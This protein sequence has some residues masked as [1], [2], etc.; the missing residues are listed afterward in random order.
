MRVLL[1]VDGVV[2]DIL[3]GLKKD[4]QLETDLN[5]VKSWHFI[6]HF[7]DSEKDLI[8]KRMRSF[9][10]WNGLPLV[11]GAKEGV[12]LLRKAG[13]EIVWVT[14]TYTGCDRWGHARMDWLARHFDAN[15]RDIIMTHSKHLVQGD[16]FVDDKIEAVRAWG[17][18]NPDGLA[19]LSDYYYTKHIDYYKFSWKNIPSFLTRT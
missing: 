18:F 4:L 15:F 12:S 16:V 11:E 13:H 6:S 9:D 2:S 10:F 14:A 5:K 7:T 8:S 3:G 19:F 17:R 1:D